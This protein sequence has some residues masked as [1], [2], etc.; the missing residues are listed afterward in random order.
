M[1]VLKGV[2]C[3]SQQSLRL[4]V[5]LCPWRLLKAGGFVFEIYIFFSRIIAFRH[6]QLP[7]AV[8]FQRRTS[9]SG[10]AKKKRGKKKKNAIT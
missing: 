2:C 8:S 1:L 9:A 6:N 4:R 10:D 7:S 5:A 3:I